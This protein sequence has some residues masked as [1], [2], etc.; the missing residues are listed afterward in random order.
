MDAIRIV[1]ACM[2]KAD[3]TFNL[4]NDGDKIA[5][6]VSG[7]KDS[8]ALLFSLVLYR[9]F[10]K[11]NFDIVPI[12]I[13]LGF[14]NYDSIN[15]SKY[16]NKLGL[17]LVVADGK[18]VY[19]ILK[20][21][22][23]LQNKSILPCS[24]CSRMKK[25]IINKKAKELN[26]N[27]VSFAH[28]K[29]DAIE[30]L[31]LNE[32]YGGRIATFEPK[33]FLENEAITFIRP[34]ILIDEKTII[35][36]T[37]EENIPI[38]SSNCPNDKK[39]KREDIKNLLLDINKAYPSSIDN[40][41]TMLSNKE[42]FNLFFDHEEFKVDNKNLY[43]RKITDFCEVI[44]ENKYIKANNELSKST[45]HFHLFA[46]N[47]LV[48]ILLLKDNGHQFIIE[49]LYLEKDEYFIPFIFKLYKNYGEKICP[50]EFV[51]K[52]RKYLQQAKLMKFALKKGLYILDINPSNLDAFLKKI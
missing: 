52:G 44:D 19:P 29:T 49:K 1:L 38:F 17:N 22:Q 27:K 18:T 23:K 13:D 45:L 35:R 28:H 26:C 25:A 47:E 10:S 39:T 2:K 6:G 37:K 14:P 30:T 9:K 7:G 48:G 32:I 33:M 16:C 20:E 41:L 36:L 11:I 51:L 21:Q 42:Q 12:N 34:F 8:M 15:I 5:L 4:I 31:F 40:F 43:Y 24:I 46:N 3:Q 50:I